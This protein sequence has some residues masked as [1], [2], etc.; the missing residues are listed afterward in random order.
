MG[1]GHPSGSTCDT[2]KTGL[3]LGQRRRRLP[4]IKPEFVQRVVFGRDI[5]FTRLIDDTDSTGPITLEYTPGNYGLSINLLMGSDMTQ[6]Y[7]F[8]DTTWVEA[9]SLFFSV[10][11][12]LWMLVTAVFNLDFD[13]FHFFTAF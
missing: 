11:R 5:Y 8:Q 6:W 1:G 7:I 3:L 4:N 13:S 10:S 2:A 12:Q 9:H